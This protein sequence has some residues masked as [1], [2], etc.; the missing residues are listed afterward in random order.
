M[1]NTEENNINFLSRDQKET[2]KFYTTNDYL[3]INALLWEEDDSTIDELIKIINDDGRG[4]LQEAIEMGFD[5]RWNCSKERG[6]E[7]YEIYTKRFPIINDET[8][9]NKIIERARLDIDNMFNSLTISSEHL[10]LYRNIKTRFIKKYKEGEVINY[11]GFSSCSLNPHIPENSTYG[12]S[13]CTLFEIDV[14]IGTKMI[15]IDLMEDIRNEDDEIILPPMKFKISKID[16]EGNK[17]YM[18]C[19]NG[20]EI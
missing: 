17:I 20:L 3:L 5:V 4:V 15:R 14:P 10:T 19:F 11:K 7:I 18:S 13:N 1:K 12:S 16:R 6:E 9:K 8:I 2:L